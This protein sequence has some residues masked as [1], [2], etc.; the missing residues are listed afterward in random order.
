MWRMG[1]EG[2]AVGPSVPVT[3][4]GALVATLTALWDDESGVRVSV[5]WQATDDLTADAARALA[6]AVGQMADLPKPE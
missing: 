5:D 3:A 2:T 4:D 1:A 6:N